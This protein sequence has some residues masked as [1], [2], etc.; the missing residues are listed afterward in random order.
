MHNSTIAAWGVPC[1]AAE[2]GAQAQ[3][4][5]ESKSTITAF[6]IC[7]RDGQIQGAPVGRLPEE[8][9]N[10]IVKLFRGSALQRIGQKWRKRIACCESKCRP[11]DH[12]TGK[13]KQKLR[14]EPR[15]SGL[16]DDEE[17]NETLDATCAYY[18]RHSDQRQRFL[19]EFLGESCY[20]RHSGGW[21]GKYNKV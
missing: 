5:V 10:A 21:F 2:I 18:E 13:E 15:Y 20:G 17:L 12:Y 1:S 6:R 11:L 19:S 14:A 3:T 9:I 8:L 7:I 16:N 4:Y